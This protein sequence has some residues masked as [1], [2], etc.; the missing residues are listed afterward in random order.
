MKVTNKVLLF[1]GVYL[2]IFSQ[3]VLLLI[4]LGKAEPTTFIISTFAA[5]GV[6]G[7]FAAWIKNVKIKHGKD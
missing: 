5:F 6:E 7:G 1:M 2:V 4:A 3:E